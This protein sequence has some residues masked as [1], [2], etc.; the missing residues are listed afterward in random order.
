MNINFSQIATAVAGAFI[1]LI[2]LVDIETTA[3]IGHDT[4]LGFITFGVGLIAGV[5]VPL[6][7]RMAAR[8]RPSS[9]A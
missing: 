3:R 7:P 2:G 6:A 5:A 8:L 4:D 9:Q 1:A